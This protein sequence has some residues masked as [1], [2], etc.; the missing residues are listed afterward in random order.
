MRRRIFAFSL[1]LA[2][3]LALAPVS[4][5]A[6][7]DA[8]F[9]QTIAMSGARG[10]A[11]KQDGTL[12]YW[13]K[14]TY[15]LDTGDQ[16]PER[17]TP[18]KLMDDVVSVTAGEFAAV[19][20]KADGSLWFFG[21]GYAGDGTDYVSEYKSPVKIP[22][23]NVAS[24]AVGG[25]HVLALKTDGTVWGWGN[26]EVD[27]QVGGGYIGNPKKPILVFEDAVRIS[28]GYSYSMAVKSDGSLWG[29]GGNSLGTLGVETATYYNN[30]PIHIMDGVKQVKAHGWSTYVIKEDDSLWGWGDGVGRTRPYE[31]VYD[32][33]SDSDMVLRAWLG[34]VT[35]VK[36]GGIADAASYDGATWMLLDT[37]GV[38]EGFGSNDMW[39]LGLG[40]D[41]R[42]YSESEKIMDGVALPGST[43]SAP[44][45]WAKPDVEKAKALGLVPAS[46][47]SRYGANIT[48]AEFAALAVALTETVTGEGIAD[49][50]TSRGVAA[51]PLFTD[52]ADQNVAAMAALG[53][54]NGVGGG[55][56]NP[57]GD[58]T[59]EQA[60]RLLALLART[61]GLAEPSAAEKFS[62]GAAISDW[63]REY[64]AFAAGHG[65]MNGTGGGAFSPKA[66]YTREAAIVTMLRL[67]NLF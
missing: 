16:S 53:V 3:L 63:A 62:D 41:E 28:A 7:Y 30:R 4:A 67:H 39:A 48:R 58:I 31:V 64:V 8:V 55:K 42:D 24:V 46:L 54:I 23:D 34:G 36:M 20:T 11:I 22:I 32:A 10:F 40:E 38:L 60:A 56:F 18:A 57:G 50:L 52:T 65:V 37:S 43:L 61:L 17:A 26:S 1:V 25:M 19:I 5:S 47:Q 51:E 33:A 44:S 21:S 29:W 45:E 12:W 13:G 9:G 2:A 6:A 35:P 66:P 14:N 49:Y 27:G 15:N 59:R